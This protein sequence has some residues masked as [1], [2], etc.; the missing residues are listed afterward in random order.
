MRKV[1]VFPP[2]HSKVTTFPTTLYE[3][4]DFSSMKVIRG[5]DQMGPC[6]NPIKESNTQA[7]SSLSFISI[8]WFLM[9]QRYRESAL[10]LNVSS[11][12]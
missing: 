6:R 10:T 1:Q 4:R 11:T 3:P 9:C 7:L 8:K 5:E 2:F 12:V